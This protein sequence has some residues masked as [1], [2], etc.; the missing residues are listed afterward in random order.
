MRD[1]TKFYGPLTVLVVV[2]SFLPLY[3][4]V[5]YTTDLGSNLTYEYGTLWQMAGNG[6]GSV[7]SLGLALL[8]AL[9]V[10]LAIATLGTSRIAIPSTIAVLGAMMMLM[11]LTKPATG[12]HPPELTD[13]GAGAVA[14]AGCA[15]VVALAHVAQLAVTGQRTSLVA[16][17]VAE[18]ADE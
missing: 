1:L 2:W 8:A 10:L 17:A 7:A 4:T 14:L 3:D 12:S 5:S 6:N 11:L 18:D 13:T 16:V 9:T 15:V